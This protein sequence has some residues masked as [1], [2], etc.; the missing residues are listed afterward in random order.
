LRGT[1]I[2]AG[3][4]VEHLRFRELLRSKIVRVHV[5][6]GREASSAHTDDLFC[7]HAIEHVKVRVVGH[8]VDLI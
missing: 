4:N 3:D 5:P 7:R 2:P 6:F 1:P 8:V